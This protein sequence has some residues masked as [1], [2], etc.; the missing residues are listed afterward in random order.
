MAAFAT[1]AMLSNSGGSGGGFRWSEFTKIFGG[2]SKD[3]VKALGERQQRLVKMLVK[4]SRNT[5]RDAENQLKSLE[6]DMVRFSA[7]GA[8]A[9]EPP[10]FARLKALISDARANLEQSFTDDAKANLEKAGPV[11]ESLQ[12]LMPQT[13]TTQ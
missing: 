3:P 7:Q 12:K 11:I 1:L 5:L 6:A 2:T 13:T 8:G 9:Q 10:E 4:P